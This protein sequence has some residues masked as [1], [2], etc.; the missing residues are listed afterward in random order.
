[1]GQTLRPIFVVSSL[2]GFLS[3]NNIFGSIEFK[4]IVMCNL[5]NILSDKIILKNSEHKL[6]SSFVNS[7]KF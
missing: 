5:S 3:N 1:M 2:L 4:L 7:K 6:Y